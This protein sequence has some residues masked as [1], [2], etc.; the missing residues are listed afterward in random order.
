MV[1]RIDRYSWG[2]LQQ[3]IFTAGNFSAL[4]LFGNVGGNGT[5]PDLDML[6]LSAQW[7]SG[8][9]EQ[10]DR[11]ET[12]AALW[13]VSRS[14]LM[15]AGTLPADPQTLAFETNPVALEAHGYGNPA[16]PVYQVCRPS[17]LRHV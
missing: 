2:G 9:V 13:M 10:A 16:I 12:I 15:H 6:P 8:S 14:A 4:G 7:W 1:W 5:H 17:L 11:G 3:N